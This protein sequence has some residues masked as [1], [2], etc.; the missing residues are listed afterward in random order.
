MPDIK[1]VK[2]EPKV[3][4]QD[5]VVRALEDLLK[6]AQAGEVQSVYAVCVLDNGDIATCYSN[7]GEYFKALGAI[8]YL[9]TRVIDSL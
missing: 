9:K 5:D 1:I 4:V 3:A 7:H 6:R 2:F 8:E